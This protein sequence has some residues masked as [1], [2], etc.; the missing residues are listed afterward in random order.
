MVSNPHPPYE[1]LQTRL[2]DFATMQK[3]RR[4]SRYWDLIGNSGNF[5]ETTP[6]L[7]RGQPS[8]FWSFMCWT[9]WLY[10][11]TNRTDSIALVRLM[12]L[13][14]EFLTQELKLNLEE[15]AL[16]LWHDYQR[17]G[18]RDKLAFLKPFLT[19]E[20]PPSSQPRKSMVPK[21]QAR[22]LV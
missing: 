14:F 12:E 4:F 21:R 2:L 13:L 15:A 16:A 7:W 6:L 11:R 22:H 1:I 17:G 20:N 8:P 9:D 10:A 19:P 18:R 5:V 3:L